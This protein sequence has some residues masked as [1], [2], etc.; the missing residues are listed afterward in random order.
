MSQH[1]HAHQGTPKSLTATMRARLRRA[2]R[3][4]E[5]GFAKT[6]WVI[7]LN[8][9]ILTVV[10]GGAAAYAT[11]SHSVELTVDGETEQIRTFATTV[12]E[13]LESRDIAIRE[14]D[15][16]NVAVSAPL[17]QTDEIV[18]EYA[19]PV[20]ITVDGSA[21]E[22]IAYEPTVGDLLDRHGIEPAEDDYV[23][24]DHADEIPREGLD[25]VV[26]TTK[27][28]QVVADG[29]TR[30]V[31]TAAPSVAEVLAEAGVTLGESDEV[32]PG[33]D[34]LVAPDAVL[35][36]VRVQ[37]E[38]RTEEVDVPFEVQTIEDPE[39]LRGDTTVETPGTVGRA[40]ETVDVVIADGEVRERVVLERE[41]LVEPTPQVER[42]GTRAP[43][44]ANF[45]TGDSVWD[46]LA[47]C[48]SGGN[49]AT[50]TGNGYYGGVQFSL[51]TW[52]SMGGSGL[53][54]EASREE[55]IQRASALQARSG[56]GQ[57]PSC[58]RK[59]GLL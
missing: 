21:T 11:F 19:K 15:R 49:W 44:A 54:S 50:N 51:P 38:T 12:D 28:L 53:P 31:Q 37:T 58:A 7:A 20:T 39:L 47:Q 22:E 56:W 10:A 16:I 29:E 40:V 36:V 34:T 57:W 3:T 8:V 42:V 5:G 17:D 9:F 1:H 4:P 30:S 41:V 6:P 24:E 52:R 35:T 2:V 48:E 55:Q 45:A 32:D 26:S 59:L 18:V 23:S 13:V 46:R 43:A 33:L 25:V 27:N 14:D